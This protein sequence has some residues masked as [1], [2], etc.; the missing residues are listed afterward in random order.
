M[1]KLLAFLTK[2]KWKI[3]QKATDFT[4]RRGERG[5]ECMHVTQKGADDSS[6]G[7][8]DTGVK[9]GAQM[10]GGRLS[11]VENKRLA[12]GMS[13]SFLN[14]VSGRVALTKGTTTMPIDLQV[15][16]RNGCLVDTP[17]SIPV[18]SAVE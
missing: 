7:L 11:R 3:L 12:W 16:A 13:N 4:V 17:E 5:L 14:R 9:F 10:R 15:P 18:L 8:P 6:L 1:G 2:K